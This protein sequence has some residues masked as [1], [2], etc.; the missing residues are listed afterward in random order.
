MWV[1][2][3]TLITSSDKP[4]VGEIESENKLENEQEYK[5]LHLIRT[6]R[7]AEPTRTVIM[8]YITSARFCMYLQRRD[9]S[10]SIATACSR[11]PNNSR[12]SAAFDCSLLLLLVLIG[13]KLFFPALDDL[14]G[15]NSLDIQIDWIEMT[16]KAQDTV[17]LRKAAGADIRY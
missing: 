15:R 1:G 8:T 3:V 17:L 6:T 5:N 2:Y 4:C 13:L 12:S 14:I 9:T 11:Y 7:S 16:E 10:H